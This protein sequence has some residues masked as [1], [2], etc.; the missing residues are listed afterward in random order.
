MM[1][2]NKKPEENVAVFAVKHRHGNVVTSLLVN[3]VY[4]TMHKQRGHIYMLSRSKAPK[5]SRLRLTDLREKSLNFFM[6]P[7]RRLLSSHN[8]FAVPV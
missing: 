1:L 8:N 2:R 5:L 3:Y 4:I 7:N 6:A